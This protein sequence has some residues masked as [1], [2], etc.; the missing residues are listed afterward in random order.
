[1]ATEAGSA[2]CSGDEGSTTAM[3]TMPS[4]NEEQALNAAEPTL[5]IVFEPEYV[6][7]IGMVESPSWNRTRE[8]GS[9]KAS[10]ATWVMDVYVPEPM[11]PV[12]LA[13]TAVPS[14]LIRATALADVRLLWWA[15]PAI[16]MPISRLPSRRIRG[17]RRRDQ[18]KASAPV[19]R[20]SAKR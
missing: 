11:S 18:P 6:G 8:T 14:T 13:T 12:A 19:R 16:P 7:A 10:A 20:Q 3:R 4:R 9:P 5:A 2:L 17:G 15:A 1:M